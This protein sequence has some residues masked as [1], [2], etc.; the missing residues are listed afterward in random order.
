[1]FTLPCYTKGSC[2]KIL[3]PEELLAELDRIFPG[4]GGQ[5]PEVYAW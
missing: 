3:Y 4:P 2:P 5:A 1:M